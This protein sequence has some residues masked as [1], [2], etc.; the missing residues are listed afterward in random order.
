[1][2]YSERADV[3]RQLR[4]RY[5]GFLTSVLWKLTGDRE[6][7]VE[8]MLMCWSSGIGQK[9]RKLTVSFTVI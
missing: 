3:F 2:K 4:T 1:M 6:L 8:A 9:I 7:F 5:S